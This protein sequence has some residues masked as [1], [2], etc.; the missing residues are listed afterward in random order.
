[1]IE[2]HLDTF[3]RLK[4]WVVSISVDGVGGLFNYIRCGADF[5][6]VDRGIK[7]L[8]LRTN[9]KTKSVSFNSIIMKSTLTTIDQ[10]ID[11]VQSLGL[12]PDVI[13]FQLIHGDNPENFFN[14][15]DVINAIDWDTLL[16]SAIER[17]TN[18]HCENA[19]K[20][21]I[22]VRQQMIRGL[23]SHYSGLIKLNHDAT[24]SSFVNT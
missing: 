6:N 9:G 24:D 10:L 15:P 13:S 8:I 7:S 16:Q 18:M 22:L 12:S 11:Y 20:H 21:L 3:D 1:M 5:N 14:N 4:N 17:L 2:D 19:A 23:R